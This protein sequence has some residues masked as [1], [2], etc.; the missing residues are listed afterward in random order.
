[1]RRPFLPIPPPVILKALI[2]HRPTRTRLRLEYTQ[3]DWPVRWNYQRGN[4]TPGKGVRQRQWSL[5]TAQHLYESA[6]CRKPKQCHRSAGEAFLHCCK[7]LALYSHP[8]PWR[9]RPAGRTRCLGSHTSCR[10][11][12]AGALVD[13]PHSISSA[14][15]RVEADTTPD[16]SRELV[17]PGRC[18]IG[19]N[20]L[21]FSASPHYVRPSCKASGDSS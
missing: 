14:T 1:M 13:G 4:S 19:V 8:R 9:P 18:P 21:Q 17:L 6:R 10:N 11:T 5:L 12:R 16:R 3:C 15:W 2:K 7:F 20:G